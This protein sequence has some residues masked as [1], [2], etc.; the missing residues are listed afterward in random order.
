MKNIT[1]LIDTNIILDSFFDREPFRDA[2]KAIIFACREGKFDGYIAAHSVTNIF[3]ILR[4]KYSSK[5]RKDLLLELCN[6]FGVVGVDLVK[7]LRA[8]NDDT[9]DDIEDYLQYDCAIEAGADYIV[10]RNP[11]DFT[12]SSITVISPEEFLK[13]FS[14]QEP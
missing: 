6:V 1:A 14:K 13:Y 7:L 5:E 9:F 12:C 11:D 10:T 8:L 3:Y 4:K 2:A